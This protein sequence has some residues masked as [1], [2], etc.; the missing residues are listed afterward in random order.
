MHFFPS[1]SSS[2]P[3]DQASFLPHVTCT[4]VKRLSETAKT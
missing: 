4:H 1:A 2:Y 3:A